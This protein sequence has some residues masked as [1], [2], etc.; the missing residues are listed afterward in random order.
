MP[1]RE[2]FPAGVPSWIDIAQPD[3]EAAVDF[4]GGL[5]GWQFTERTFGGP[6]DRYLVASLDDREVA[7]I[8]PMEAEP[9]LPT[10][11]ETYVGVDDADRSAGLVRAAGGAVLVEPFDVGD[12]GRA[13]VCADLE[14]ATFRLW[15]PG[16]LKGAESVN[17]PGAWNF[18]ELRTP[19]VDAAAPFYGAVFGWET[20]DV[21][22]GSGPATMVRLPGYAD[23]LERR[24]PDLRSRM[25]A[26]DAP[27][28]FEDAVA[29]LVPP[30]PEQA[31][32][33]R[34]HWAITFA[35]DDTDAVARKA[36]ELGGTV[37]VPPFDAG[38]VRNAVLRDPG[39]AQLTVGRYDPDS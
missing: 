17:V 4:Y 13:A 28:G 12:L 23:F 16:R 25:A 35:V 36:A 14:G 24:D 1:E 20:S 29:S 3:L 9:S 33:A 11:W 27:A 8:R 2:G 32:E 31:E 22:M 6:D 37:E 30:G 39:G 38:P 7:G 15:Q 21:D 34:P 10:A 26:N 19:D 5:F 18:S